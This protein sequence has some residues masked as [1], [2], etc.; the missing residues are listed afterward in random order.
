M[1]TIFT[2]QTKTRDEDVVFMSSVIRF[3]FGHNSCS[4]TQWEFQILP[5]EVNDFFFS[6]YL[7]L[8]AAIGLGVYSACNRNEY[9]KLK[10]K[11]FLVSRAQPAPKADNLTA[12]CEPIV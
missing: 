11:I 2:V 8:P 6:I 7:I 10:K 3:Y 12:I 4:H 9:Q 5:D 1:C